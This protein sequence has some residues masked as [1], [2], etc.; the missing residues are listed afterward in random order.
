MRKNT[1]YIPEYKS[2]PEDFIAL[3][4]KELPGLQPGHQIV[5]EGPRYIE[6]QPEFQRLDQQI[7]ALLEDFGVDISYHVHEID[8][9]RNV[10][11]VFKPQKN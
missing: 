5:V 7:V 3:L 11:Y 10:Y 4:R 1:K 9:E 8:I 6:K 2:N